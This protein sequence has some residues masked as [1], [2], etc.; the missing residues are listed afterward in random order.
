MSDH[1][2][3]ELLVDGDHVRV[4]SRRCRSGC[5]GSR[6][7]ARSALQHGYL[8]QQ[9]EPVPR[10]AGD[11][12][13][14][15]KPQSGVPARC[16]PGLSRPARRSRRAGPPWC[17]SARPGGQCASPPAPPHPRRVPALLIAVPSS[18][19][20]SSPRPGLSAAHLVQV[21]LGGPPLPGQQR[22]A[23]PR[24]PAP[25]PA[26]APAARPGSPAGPGPGSPRLC[27]AGHRARRRRP[28]PV[29]P[30]SS[31]LSGS[32]GPSSCA[33]A[34]ACW[35]RAVPAPRRR[36]E[37][38]TTG[39]EVGAGGRSPGPAG[40]SRVP[41]HGAGPE[42]SRAEPGLAGIVLESSSSAASRRRGAATSAA[43]TGWSMGIAATKHLVAGALDHLVVGRGV[44]TAR[45]ACSLANPSPAAQRP[46]DFRPPQQGD[47][48]CAGRLSRHHPDPAM[49]DVTVTVGC[50]MMA[51]AV[52]WA[53]GPPLSARSVTV[54]I[55][56]GSCGCSSTPSGEGVFHCQRCG[57]D[58]ST[59]CA[60][61]ARFFSLLLH[62]DHPAG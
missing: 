48:L 31:R 7:R 30:V 21:V 24:P 44:D 26:A 53:T 8:D 40:S 62:P 11:H 35:T 61:G 39:T 28:P 51:G 4:G 10:C 20:A 19:G 23:R 42:P 37:G 18:R 45:C 47:G 54:P 2:E 43:R 49:T 17:S 41:S 13:S 58:R 15:W 36:Y 55:I 9:P 29:S 5:A 50:A 6:A 1:L 56:F 3:A 33:R 46:V 27:P 22:I 34:A 16:R 60:A 14:C 52:D 59:G 25:A 12:R 32:P 57:G 38:L